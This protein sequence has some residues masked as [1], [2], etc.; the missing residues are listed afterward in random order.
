M[1]LSALVSG[2]N[3]LTQPRYG[4]ELTQHLLQY[5]LGRRLRHFWQNVHPREPGRQWRY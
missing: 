4:H 2:P 5:P 1:G 3:I